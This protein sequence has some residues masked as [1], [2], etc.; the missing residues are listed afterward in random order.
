MIFAF[1]LIFDY[2]FIFVF[3]FVFPHCQF[4]FNVRKGLPAVEQ[5]Q[6]EN[7]IDAFGNLKVDTDFADGSFIPRGKIRF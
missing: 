7:V 5:L 1:L 2:F 4:N 6:R 3:V